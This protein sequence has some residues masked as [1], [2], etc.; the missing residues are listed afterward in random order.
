MNLISVFVYFAIHFFIK[1]CVTKYG[2]LACL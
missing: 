1:L 2:V